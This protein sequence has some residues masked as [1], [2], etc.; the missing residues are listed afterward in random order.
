MNQNSIR[1]ARIMAEAMGLIEPE[2]VKPP[3][4][5]YTWRERAKTPQ[6]SE[7]QTPVPSP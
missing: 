1:I 3:P 2:K 4:K 5:V 6:T 7:E